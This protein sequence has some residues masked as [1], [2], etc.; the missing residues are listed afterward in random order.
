V[1]AVKLVAH[2]LPQKET[3]VLRSLRLVPAISHDGIVDRFGQYAKAEWPGKIHQEA[4]L[5][6]RREDEA[7]ELTRFPLLPDRDRFG[8]WADG[9]ERRATG[10][11]RVERIDGVWWLV[12]PDGRLFFSSGV[13]CLGPRNETIISGREKF[14]EWLPDEAD[15]LA[16][17]FGRTYLVLRGPVKQ[18]RTFDFFM[19]NLRRK[20]GDSFRDDWYDVSLRRLRSW[21]FNTIGNWSDHAFYRN[22]RVP[23]VATVTIDGDHARVS[24]GSDYWGRMHDPFDPQFAPDTERAIRPVADL[25]RGDPWCIGYFVDNELSWA[26]E[27]PSG[28]YGLALGALKAPPSSPAHRAFMEMLKERH[29]TIARFNEFWGTRFADWDEL[30]RA[31]FTPKPSLEDA[32]SADL[33]DFVSMLAERYFST[34]RDALRKADPDHLY[35]GCRFAWRNSQAIWVASK[36]C[37][38]ISFNIYQKQVDPKAWDILNEVEGPSIIGEYHFGALDRG[39]FHTGLVPTDSQADRAVSFQTY[40]QSVLDHPAL[41]GCHW[42]QYLDQPLTGRPLDGENYNIGLVDITDSPYPELIGAARQ[43]HRT[44]YERRAAVKAPPQTK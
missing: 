23:Y 11:F 30:D 12:G 27:G 38:V 36:Y 1:V 21:G 42:F 43:V 3:V 5:T 7:L 25:V 44:M 2:Q 39:M 16:A 13:D 10:F 29:K 35:L 41:V 24:S 22:G 9:P 28:Q 32:N 26:G 15:P 20:Y 31:A 33:G 14:F 6:K 40:L 18:G 19:T 17:G 4:D 8:G 37:D 34:V